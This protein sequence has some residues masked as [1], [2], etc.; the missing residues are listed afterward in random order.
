[1]QC[2][3][4]NVTHVAWNSKHKIVNEIPFRVSRRKLQIQ[5]E[6]KKKSGA[7]SVQFRRVL[8]YVISSISA[9][10]KMFPNI[11]STMRPVYRAFYALLPVRTHGW[12]R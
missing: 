6:R 8:K 10:F 2:T 3:Q 7:E 1:M 11:Y 4:Q 9:R 5:C 12:N